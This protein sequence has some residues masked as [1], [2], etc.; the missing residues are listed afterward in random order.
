MERRSEGLID[1]TDRRKMC[2]ADSCTKT[3]IRKK[4]D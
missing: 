2:G 3:W 4:T 1:S